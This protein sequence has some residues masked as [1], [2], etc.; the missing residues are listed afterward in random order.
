MKT[1]LSSALVL[2][3]RKGPG[4]TNQVGS[5]D[6]SE[7]LCL[8]MSYDIS[9]RVRTQIQISMQEAVPWLQ[10]RGKE[11]WNDLCINVLFCFALLFLKYDRGV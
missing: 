3:D 2:R 9:E 4:G 1:L 7:A 5:N 11:H 8:K 10:Q 6:Q